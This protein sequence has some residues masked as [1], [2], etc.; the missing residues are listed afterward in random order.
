MD[1]A[2]LPEENRLEQARSLARRLRV[3]VDQAKVKLDDIP[4]ETTE[5]L[6]RQGY[7]FHEAQPANER[8]AVKGK[9]APSIRLS[10]EPQTEQW[11][12]DAHTLASIPALEKI[13]AAKTEPPKPAQSEVPVARRSPRATM[14]TFIDSMNGRTS[15]SLQEAVLCLD[16]RG[17]DPELWGTRSADLA[18]KLKA[19]IDKIKVVVFAEISDDPQGRSPGEPYIFYT[20]GGRQHYHR[21]SR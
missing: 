10:Y 9:P 1:I 4:A 19:V 3:L 6:K 8:P 17:Q 15:E 11:R 20:S 12:F 2:Q 16:P 13:L 7:I 21:P 18:R 14:Q 5:L